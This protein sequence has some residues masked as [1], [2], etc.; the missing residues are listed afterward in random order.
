[1]KPL[2]RTWLEELRAD[3][4]HLSPEPGDGANQNLWC[5]SLPSSEPVTTAELVE[6]LRASMAVR[7]E[8]VALQSVRPVSFYA[9]LDEMAGQLRFSTACCTRNTLPFGAR[10]ALLDDPNELAEAF[11]RS[12]YRDGIPWSE[13]REG[14]RE[15]FADDRSVLDA[16]E[17]KV[18]ALEW[19]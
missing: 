6:F 17:L 1:M 5:I 7:A 15:A 18:W 11:A 2:F 13:L 4:L 14:R 3:G 19:L 12:P 9:W 8:L 10:P 16:G